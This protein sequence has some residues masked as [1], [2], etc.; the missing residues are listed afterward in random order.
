[1]IKNNLAPISSAFGY[2]IVGAPLPERPEIT[3]SRIMWGEAIEGT[4]RELLSEAEDDGGNRKGAADGGET[5]ASPAAQTFLEAALE[6]GERPQ[7]EIAVEGA[8][9]G[10]SSDRLFR[11]SKAMRIAKRKDG[12]NGPWLWSLPVPF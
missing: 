6:A 4:A 8:E 7:K 9:L 12:I 10:F 5:A 2:S 11:A 1:M 3:A